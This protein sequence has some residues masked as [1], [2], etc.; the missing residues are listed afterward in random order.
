MKAQELVTMLQ[1]HYGG[2]PSKPAPGYL[3]AEVEAPDS[4]RRAD[5]IWLPLDGYNR[6][7]IIGHEIK[8]SRSDVL[9]ELADPSKAEAWAKFCNRWW[10]VVADPKLVDGLEIPEGWGIMA[11]PSGPRSRRLMTIVRKAPDRR[12]QDQHSAY[13]Q[14]LAR[15]F[16]KGDDQFSKVRSLEQRLLNEQGRNATLQQENGDLSR[17]LAGYGHRGG[18]KRI[19]DFV[20]EVAIELNKPGEGYDWE[21]RAEAFAVDPQLVVQGL[22]DIGRLTDAARDLLRVID[23]KTWEVEAAMQEPDLADVRSALAATRKALA[24]RIPERNLRL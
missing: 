15:I 13:A 5:A 17:Q 9:A 20:R 10:L 16:Y 19:E 24:D 21:A 18:T 2:T 6:G 4:V 23:R 22:L 8:V 14:L 1:A 11:P 12:P 3:A 7:K